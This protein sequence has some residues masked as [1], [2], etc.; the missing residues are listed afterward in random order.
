MWYKR[1]FLVVL[2]ILAILIPIFTFAQMKV[3]QNVRKQLGTDDWR[4]AV[5]Q[6]ISDYTN[7]MSSSRVPE[8]WKKW[9][10]VTVQQLQYYLEKDIDPTAPNA[11]TFARE[12]MENSVTLFLPLLVV[13]LAS[14]IVSAELSGGTIKLLVSRPVSRWKILLSKCIALIFYISLSVLA[15]LVLSYLISGILFGY[16]GWNAPVLAGFSVV[17]ADV[18][19]SNVHILTSWQ[20]ILMEYGLA[21]F[22]AICVGIISMMV[23]VLVRSTAVSMGIM[24]ASI[25]SGVILANMVSSWEQAKYFFMVNLNLIE[26]LNGS[27]PPIAG[28]NLT[29]SLAVLTV[30]TVGSLI[31]SFRVF[32]KQDIY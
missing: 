15:V 17:G 19:T 9:F 5:Q 26:Y 3:A 22:S 30:W 29:F 10:S 31:V 4:V 20:Y 16:G 27:I 32:T 8:E 14:D 23:S 1:R 24:L 11:V 25:I 12:F 18:D 28:M 2:I 21:W 6:Q 13:I 7:R